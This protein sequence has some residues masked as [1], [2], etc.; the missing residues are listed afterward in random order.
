MTCRKAFIQRSVEEFLPTLLLFSERLI[1]S[2]LFVFA[3]TNKFVLN[4]SICV[5]NAGLYVCH[6]FRFSKPLQKRI[7]IYTPVKTDVYLSYA[8]TMPLKRLQH[9]FKVADNLV[10]LRLYCRFNLVA[11]ISGAG[12]NILAGT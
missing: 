11:A 7:I 6:I 2:A 8:F 9:A 4:T 10:S 5:N 3:F 1:S 12:S